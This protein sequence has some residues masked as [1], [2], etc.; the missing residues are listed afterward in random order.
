[1]NIGLA[2]AQGII[3]SRQEGKYLS[4]E[5]FQVRTHLNKSGMDALRKENC[6]AG[7]PEKNQMSLFA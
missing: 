3:S 2:A 5:D 6:F 7:L 4:I 1:P